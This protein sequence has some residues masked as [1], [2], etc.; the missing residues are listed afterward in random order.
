[1][2][3]AQQALAHCLSGKETVCL[4][5]PSSTVIWTVTR[6]MTAGPDAR[7][8]RALP[9]PALCNPRQLISWA[10]FPPLNMKKL[11]ETLRKCSSCGRLQTP[12]LDFNMRSSLAQGSDI[13]QAEGLSEIGPMSHLLPGAQPGCFFSRT[14]KT[15]VISQVVLLTYLQRQSSWDIR[16]SLGTHKYIQPLR[17][18]PQGSPQDWLILT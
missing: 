9:G 12:G 11:E 16:E 4:F 8:C 18:G 3:M 1:M 14:A 7:P 2:K 17:W 10:Q 6:R 13:A 15:V 5:L